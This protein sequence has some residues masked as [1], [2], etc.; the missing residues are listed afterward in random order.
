MKKVYLVLI[1]ALCAPLFGMTEKEEQL[2]A[3]TKQLYEE[4]A[5]E[6]IYANQ[7]CN[8]KLANTIV[9]NSSILQYLYRNSMFGIT[10]YLVEN[11]F[12][13]PE[14]GVTQVILEIDE[15]IIQCNG[16]IQHLQLIQNILEFNQF[17]QVK[18]QKRKH[19]FIL[20]EFHQE[21]SLDQIKFVYKGINHITNVRR[22]L[23]MAIV[24][25]TNGIP[26]VVWKEVDQFKLPAE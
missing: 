23:E 12:P 8:I 4:T 25:E 6:H 26:E 20:T 22:P 7:V 10:K 15:N 24:K 2:Y 13:I 21:Y 5:R 1:A 9:G 3:D 18:S 16:H 14:I 19:N 17:L 11:A